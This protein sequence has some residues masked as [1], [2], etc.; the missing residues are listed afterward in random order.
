MKK[1]AAVLVMIF[2]T[3]QLHS[4]G[5]STTA[6]S[7]TSTPMADSIG[8]IE[9]GV[10]ATGSGMDGNAIS[11]FSRTI[12]V[13]P[14]AVTALTSSLCDTHGRPQLPSGGGDMPNSDERYPYVHTYCAMTVNDGDTVMG[15]F[16]LAKGLICALEKGGIEFSGVA[17]TIVADMND[18]TCWPDGAPESGSVT[19]SAT[20]SS[21]ASFNSHYDKGVV[22]TVAS[23]GLTFKIAANLD[24]DKIEFIAHE[25]WDGASAGTSLG[26]TGVMAG[27]ITKST[28]VLRFEKRDERVRA[29]CTVSSC[30]WNRHSRIIANLTMSGG[31]PTGLNTFEYGYSS[32][33]V[34]ATAIGNGADTSSS[35]IVVTGKGDL[36]G[37]IK[38]R[39]FSASGKT[40]AQMQTIG[41]WAETTNTACASSTGINDA[42]DCGGETGIA[43]AAGGTKFML[44]SSVAQTTPAAWLAA[45]TGFN[46]TSMNLDTDNAF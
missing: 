40:T 20:G 21:P 44:Y 1:S 10:A 28:G 24:G 25:N 3:T 41:Q 16:S 17:Q 32:V 45:F 13:V 30:G 12:A 15:G 4:C 5:S 38:A 46:F 26:N 14:Y 23:L 2:A 43:N 39:Y 36:T 7:A 19:L 8:L 18:A 9:D 6:A 42:A 34:S 35:G 31:S 37:E 27:E 11:G 29:S 22:F 33:N